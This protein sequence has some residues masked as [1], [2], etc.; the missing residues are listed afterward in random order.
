[1]EWCAAMKGTVWSY[2]I[3][4]C[5]GRESLRII[6]RACRVRDSRAHSPSG[7]PAIGRRGSAYPKYG[8][9]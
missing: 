2:N 3:K 4:D 8:G 7:H 9:P 5:E 6:A 1:M